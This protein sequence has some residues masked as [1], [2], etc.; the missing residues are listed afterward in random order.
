MLMCTAFSVFIHI[1]TVAIH[2]IKL[3]QLKLLFSLL[4]VTVQCIRDGQFVVVVA[5]DT[6]VPQLNLNSVHLLGNES[7]C[8]PVGIT[9]AFIIFQFPVTACGTKM[10]VSMLM[11]T[12][13]YRR[14]S[15]KQK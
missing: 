1:D 12:S 5:R 8:S 15:G 3:Y 2:F 6:T 11:L 7:S 9:A 13:R 10:I 4:L 14:C